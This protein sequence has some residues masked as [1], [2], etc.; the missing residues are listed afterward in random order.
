M[1]KTT[2][3][4]AVLLCLKTGWGQLEYHPL[5]ETNAT[6]I[7]AQILYNF[8]HEHET[9]TTVVYITGDTVINGLPYAKYGYHGR[10]DWM[11]GYG[12]PNP[13]VGSSNIAPSTG[14]FRQDTIQK[15]VFTW[16]SLN[17]TDE[18]LYDFGSLTIGQPYPETVTNYNYPYLLVMSQDSVQL[19]D[20]NYYKRWNLGTGS[21]DS[22]YV[23]V[24]EGVGGTN[25]FN[26]PIYPFFEQL[27]FLQCHKNNAQFIY[28]DW[29]FTPVPSPYS[30]DCSQTLSLEQHDQTNLVIFPN[31]TRSTISIQSNE[32][33]KFVEI[34][35]LNGQSLLR[36]ENEM[37]LDL[38][39]LKQG[40]YL[41]EI[42][43]VDG[44]STFQQVQL[45]Q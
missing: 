22:A 42:V 1:I 17:Q 25:G 19:M 2:T 5:P 33:I 14:Y 26:T 34:Y 32:P 10:M 24:I 15:T 36:Y 3:L 11:D 37:S 30:E 31:P 8:S 35:D 16:N 27:S 9:I 20:G 23:S 21:S 38:G 12:T 40:I 44:S 45:I 28:E 7:Q 29:H 4:I 39:V 41:V 13:V 43:F 18:L 6:W